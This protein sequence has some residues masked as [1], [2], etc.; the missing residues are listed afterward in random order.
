[1]SNF[2]NF[3]ILKSILLANIRSY[4]TDALNVYLIV[5]TGV[6]GTILNII[7]IFNFIICT[8][9][10]IWIIFIIKNLFYLDNFMLRNP[11][12]FFLE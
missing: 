10:V 7:T 8:K 1:M 11:H 5:P 9:S 3:S 2:S 4:T 12:F 6:L